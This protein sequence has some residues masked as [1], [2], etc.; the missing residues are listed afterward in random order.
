MFTFNFK[1][2]MTSALVTLSLV[3]QFLHF[4]GNHGL[5]VA[6]AQLLLVLGIFVLN[7]TAINHMFSGLIAIDELFGNRMIAMTVL[8]VLMNTLFMVYPFSFWFFVGVG[9]WT[10]VYAVFLKQFITAL[11]QKRTLA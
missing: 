10:A 3:L 4:F 6:G 8:G 1:T 2:F 9:A 11:K 5:L 7:R